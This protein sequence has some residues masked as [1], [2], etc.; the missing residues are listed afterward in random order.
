MTK[1][2]RLVDPL[3]GVGYILLVVAL[4]AVA[5]ATYNREFVSST[6]VKLTTGTIGNALQKGSD[7]KFHG[8]PVGRVTQIHTADNGAVLTLAL[9][10]DTAKTLPDNVTARL[11]PKT[12]FGERFVS[13]IDP[14]Q[15]SGKDLV[16]GDTIH[17]DSSSEAVELEDVFDQ[18]LPLLNSIQPEKLA[19]MMGELSTTLRGEGANIGDTLEA[20]NGYF[21]KLNPKIP[22]MTEDISK[23]ASVANTYNAAAPDLLS[24]LDE[25]TTTSK[26][27]VAERTQLKDV[28]ANVITG[29]DEATGWVGDNQ[30]RI[31]ILS[32]QSRAALEAAAPYATEFPCLFK[33]AAEFIPVMDKTLGKG[34]DEAGIHVQLNIVKSRG[35][36][37]PGKDAPTFTTGGKAR[38]PYVTGQTGTHSASAVAGQPEAFGPPPS[39]FIQDQVHAGSGLGDANS[40]AENELLAELLAPT[41]GMAPAD[42]PHWSSLVVGPTLR[43]TKVT[44]R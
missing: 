34:S 12:L 41:Q 42:Y 23:L 37:L 36:Y 31:E 22:A 21:K 19:A 33:A 28:Y 4:I 26:T 9:D 10:P 17:Q 27:L 40:P 2:N 44:L 5:L 35:K 16:A 15:S 6:D 29:A 13:L 11:L 24:A 39:R 30:N 1:S 7:V 43:N 8:V 18:L 32:D 14:A 25:L 3:L 20:W 38:C